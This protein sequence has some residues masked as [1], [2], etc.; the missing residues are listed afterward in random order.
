MKY[1]VPYKVQPDGTTVFSKNVQIT[2]TVAANVDSTKKLDTMRRFDGIEFDGTGDVMRFGV[3]NKADDGKEGTTT[4]KVVKNIKNLNRLTDGSIIAVK[5]E[6]GAFSL[7]RVTKLKIND[8]DAY[9]I[10]YQGTNIPYE[11]LKD[12]ET[13]WFVFRESENDN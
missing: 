10:F 7:G 11:L 3:A 5:F 8:F 6:G 1:G 13:Y 9:P 4:I 12:N 2:G